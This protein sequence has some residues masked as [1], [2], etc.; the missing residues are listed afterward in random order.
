MVWNFGLKYKTHLQT[1][2]QGF[3]QILLTCYEIW[4]NIKPVFSDGFNGKYMKVSVKGE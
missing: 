2:K 3:L 4:D 1:M